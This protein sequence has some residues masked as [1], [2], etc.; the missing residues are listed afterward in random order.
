LTLDIDGSWN[1]FE[2]ASGNGH[3]F[4]TTGGALFAIQNG[5]NVGIGTDSPNAGLEVLK[6]GGGKIRISE[7]SDRYVE[8]I[9]YA[10]GTAN[11][12]TMAFRTIQ[13]GTSTSTERMRIDSSGNMGLGVT[14]DTSA[15]LHVANTNTD[16][17]GALI[18]NQTANGAIRRHL[19]L[20]NPGSGGVRLSFE[21]SDTVRASI[22]MDNV[23]G[24]KFTTGNYD[25]AMTIDNSG[26]TTLGGGKNLYFNSSSGSDRS[27]VAYSSPNLEVTNVHASGVMK[28]KTADTERMR[29]NSS[30]N[31]G[32]GTSS[33]KGK[34]DVYDGSIDNSGQTG[35]RVSHIK[36]WQVK[37]VSSSTHT[38]ATVDQ[39]GHGASQ[40][41]AFYFKY[42]FRS[43]IGFN[44]GGGSHG[45]KMISGRRV[46]STSWAIDPET[47][48]CAGDSGAIPTLSCTDNGDGT[49]SIK[50]TN[51]SSTH[52]MGKLELMAW[53]CSITSPM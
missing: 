49:V 21:R 13:A 25:T 10:E 27:F 44:G 28:F 42:T 43:M 5:G 15:K 1:N 31:V 29:I 23:A 12:S 3:K 32:I 9:G 53:D 18:E 48:S 20:K 38:V 50:I 34:L 45:E 4:T 52:S 36:T 8:I 22:D 46:S 51:P 40:L 2:G 26:H 47:V 35:G 24:L 14:P 17:V 16:E 6:S 11:G 33:P 41:A 39:A 19:R 37:L 30:G 7:T